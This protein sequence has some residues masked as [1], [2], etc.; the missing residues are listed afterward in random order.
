LCD[1]ASPYPGSFIPGLAAIR[2]AVEARGSSFEAVF[3]PGAQD[4]QWYGALRRDGM[5]ARVCPP[6]SRRALP[7]WLAA[8][9]AEQQGPMILHTHFARWD[10][11]AVLVARLPRQRGP[12]AVVWHR[13][14][15][16]SR[17]PWLFTRDLVRYGLAGRLVDAH[18]CVGPGSVVQLR[19]RR[20]PTERT[21]LFP[22]PVDVRRFPM[23]SHEERL[24]AR[25]ELGVKPGV[26]V[27]VA[28]TWDWELKGGPLFIDLA[29]A[30]ITRGRRVLALAV[31]AGPRAQADARRLGVGPHLYT[32][33]PR[34]DP[35]VF[36]AAA[37]VFIAPGASEG[38]GFAP[39][40]SV[41]CGT[42]VVASDIA[43][44]RHYGSHLPAVRLTPLAAGEM[45]DAVEEEL[46]AG[47]GDRAARIAA[48]R[49]YLER[50]A[51]LDAWVERLLHVYEDALARRGALGA[52]L[53][54]R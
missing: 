16:L 13:H 24:R 35:R 1:Y 19:R 6:L 14:G 29:R 47:A 20:A 28:F 51:G 52:G 4:R 22:N 18:L 34:A 21:L 37:S 36:F 32:V 49:A 26:D 31:G 25:A 2:D 8:L 3:A 9:A 46:G 44:H 39:L 50:N 53:T 45:A 17:R 38:F 33:A 40:E 23:A 12:A 7:S 54:A 48:S 43:G 15:T 27:L 10:L 30:L 5:C 42:P 41:C 11:S